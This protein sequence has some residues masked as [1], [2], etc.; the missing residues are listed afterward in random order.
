M[1]TLQNLREERASLWDKAKNFLDTR[2]DADGTISNE[3]AA[4]YEKMV[5]KIN[6]LSKQI[7]RMEQRKAMDNYLSAPASAPIL[8][9][10]N[11]GM[12]AGI[13]DYINK[14]PGLAGKD[15]H[16]HFL[17]AFRQ[18]FST[19]QVKDSLREGALADGGFL[20][21]SEFDSQLV[22]KLAEGN[23]LREIAKVIRTASTH[24]IPVVATE[25][26]A[27]W[28]SEGEEIQLSKP[29]F[30]RKTL[31][32]FKLAV[33]SL[34]SNELLQDSYYDVETA[35]LDVFSRSLATAESEAMI[36]G[37]GEGKPKGLLAQ[38]AESP[39]SI[40]TSRGSELTA[41][42]CLAAF[43]SLER[44]YR[45]NAV[46]LASDSAVANLRRLRDANQ[47]FLWTNSL[48]EGEPPT[49]LGKKIYTCPAMPAVATGEV[50]LIFGDFADF[51]VIGDRGERT[52]R[53]LR[54]RFALTDQTAFLLISRVDAVV[55]D[56]RAFRGV[57]I[58]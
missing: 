12:N 45:Q 36:N 4:T 1:N 23:V 28:V 55:T 34:A 22:T 14:R 37:D 33:G 26:S 53:P 57:K 47:A 41:D 48:A 6:A 40:I 51:F 18:G 39:S 29:Q 49:F 2:T 21:P 42:D 52:F 20:L 8:N 19:P 13:N 30:G 5:G 46:W 43:Y 54:E 9:H 24:E 35:L 25:P 17:N 16:R 15:Y 38:M 32:A 27:Q 3:D 50:P 10:P 7:E 11:A 44:P 56:L 31:L 58:K